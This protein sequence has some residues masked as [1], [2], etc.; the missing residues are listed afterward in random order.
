[1]GAPLQG[2]V[3]P[4]LLRWV[5]ACGSKDAPT[6][7]EKFS[8]WDSWVSGD[9]TP[10]LNQLQKIAA[11]TN[12]PF[13]FLLLSDPPKVELPIPDFRSGHD[14]HPR[15]A[16]QHT[17]RE[18]QE[19]IMLMQ[20][21][22]DWYEDYL[23]SVGADVPLDFVGFSRGA[24][25]LEAAANIRATLRYE[26]DD[27]VTFKAASDAKSYL[28]RAFE[29]AGGLVVINSLVANNTSRKLDNKEFRGFTLQ[30]Q[31]APLVFV[32]SCGESVNAQV[33][34][35]LHELAHVWRGESGISADDS[36]TILDSDPQLMNPVPYPHTN[37]EI[38]RWCDLV[39]SEV[40]VPAED[41]RRRFNPGA[42]DF[43]KE[44][45]RLSDTYWCSTLVVLI[46]LRQTGLVSWQSFT[47]RY[48][49]ERE[50][51]TQLRPA[52]TSGGGDFYATQRYRIGE[53]LSRAVI[54]DLKRGRT[55]PTRALR[56]LGFSSMPMVDK[57]ARRLGE[58]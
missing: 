2:I 49:A 30:S 47:E 41:L 23:A 12:L 55:S 3:K 29:E 8:H 5:E 21:R 56:L 25:F 27:R 14:G 48:N 52:K 24:S 9:S 36:E 16:V 15:Q 22:Q 43:T 18:L 19:V 51:L 11:F 35:L 38:E 58:S 10:N 6:L 4:A 31:L 26:V 33:F 57:Y 34:S 44:L 54:R 20:L 46:R 39:A 37:R 32:N 45:Q 53:N 1:M 42:T 40:A 7:R 50:R 28:V 17:S 13:G